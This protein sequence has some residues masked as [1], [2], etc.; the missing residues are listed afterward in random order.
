MVTWAQL[1]LHQK[2]CGLLNG[3]GYFDPL[4]DLLAAPASP[5]VEKWLD[6]APT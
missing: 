4:L 5:M 1:A 2:P 3:K 6:R